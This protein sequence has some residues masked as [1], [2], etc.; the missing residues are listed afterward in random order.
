MLRLTLGRQVL[1]FLV[2]LVAPVVALAAP[3]TVSVQQAGDAQ[4]QQ[5]AAVDAAREVVALQAVVMS[6]GDAMVQMSTSGPAPVAAF[7]RRTQDVD[8]RLARLATVS[9]R[10]EPLVVQARRD[11]QGARRGSAELQETV[12]A[13]V[14]AMLSGEQPPATAGDG[15][16]PPGLARVAE[17]VVAVS[18]SLTA[19]ADVNADVLQD[20]VDAAHTAQQRSHA[21]LLGLALTMLATAALATRVLEAGVR[22]PLLRVERAAAA[23]G[24]TEHPE[25]LPVPRTRELASLATSFNGM[26]ERLADSRADLETAHGRFRALV[27]GASDVVVVV[28]A[29]TTVRFATPSAARVLGHDPEELVGTALLDR[30]VPEDRALLAGTLRSAGRDPGDPVQWRSAGGGSGGRVWLESLVVDLSDVPAVGGLVVT[31]RD[32]TDRRRLEERLSESVLRDPLTGL[33]NRALLRDRLGLALARAVRSGGPVAL[34]AV[35]LD[36]FSALNDEHGSQAGDEVLREAADRLTRVLRDEDTCARTAGDEFHVLLGPDVTSE[37]DA[38]AAAERLL[39]ALQ[40]PFR[41]GDLVLTVRASI[42][43]AC[44]PPRTD[45]DGVLVVVDAA[46][47]VAASRGG[48]RFA[49]STDEGSARL[50]RSSEIRTDL[51]VALETDALQVHYQPTVDLGTGRRVGMEALVRWTHPRFGALPPPEF[52][53][54]AEQ[55]GLIGALGRFVLRRACEDLAA[56]RREDPGGAPGSVSVNL[57]ALQLEDEDVVDVVAAALGDAGLEPSR[58]VLEVTE[59]ALADLD[60]AVPRLEALQALGVAVAVDDF[61][62]GYCSL[63]YLARLP[64]HVLKLDRAFV[65]ALEPTAPE[66]SLAAH[67]VKMARDLGLRT[68][69]EGVED[70]AQATA[71]RRLGYDLGQG[72]LWSRPVPLHELRGA[73]PVPRDDL[74]RDDLPRDDLP[75]DD[76]RALTPAAPGGRREPQGSTAA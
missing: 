74:P 61:G 71:L 45:V 31:T 65:T 66:S 12:A 63:A 67:I 27:Q 64:V 55:S 26:L 38:A 18:E 49:L 41:V 52:V 40:A 22:R 36:G 35:D 70:A 8:A 75:R 54:L 17:R 34:L 29:A 1:V 28:D 43:V 14:R 59:T 30:A 6:A 10:A 4:R 37:D 58:L 33:A 46:R 25:P 51:R 48:S 16:L 44:L 15:L 11:W 7:L 68:T 76:L 21:V 13:T 5:T 9:P 50:L 62:T 53:P 39:A 23:V 72:Y 60:V 2:V 57:S 20:A 73:V 24:G 56:W 19:L 69:A 42:G 32:V 47:R 3:G